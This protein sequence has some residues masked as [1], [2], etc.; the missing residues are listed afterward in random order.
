MSSA[1]VCE[2]RRECAPGWGALLLSLL[3]GVSLGALL[4]T[5]TGRTSEDGRD[6]MRTEA[7]ARG[8]A[9]YV[10]TDPKTGAVEW[11]WKEVPR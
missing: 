1:K 9:E 5:W 7:V 6:E 2:C 8:H 3:W 10:L 11:R 4:F